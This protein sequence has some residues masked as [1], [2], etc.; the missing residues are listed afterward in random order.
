M[1]ELNIEAVAVF[2]H[3]WQP[4]YDCRLLLLLNKF[5]DPRKQSKK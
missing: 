4:L 3:D 1:S 5:Y 2:Q